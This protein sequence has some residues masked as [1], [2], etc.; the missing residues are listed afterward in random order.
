[1][2][3][4]TFSVLCLLFVLAGSAQANPITDPVL[5]LD[6]L[7]GDAPLQPGSIPVFTN[8][9]SFF[10]NASGGGFLTF[11]NLNADWFSLL[12]RTPRPAG[13]VFPDDFMIGGSAYPNVTIT[14]DTSIDVINILFFDT[15]IDVDTIFFGDTFTINLNNLIG[16]F[17]N[18]DPAGV[19]GW[20]PLH[21]FF[22]TANPPPIPEPGTWVLISTGLVGIVGQRKIRALFHRRKSSSSSPSSE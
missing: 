18:T 13:T 4:F 16:G 5:L 10:S 20:G 8:M 1:M 2:R 14:L 19:G 7:R 17:P 9:F 21:P 6:T 12:I 15:P 22:A 3:R 11:D